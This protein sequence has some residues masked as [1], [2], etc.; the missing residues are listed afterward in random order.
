MDQ[1]KKKYR[2]TPVTYE[3]G[4]MDHY[5]VARSVGGLDSDVDHAV[6]KLLFA[7]RRGAKDKLRD[8]KE[9]KKSIEASIEI[10]EN[11]LKK[12]SE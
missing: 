7:G 10:E 8:L 4:T 1:D 11:I 5:C 9:A 12:E 3:D 2:F 6:K